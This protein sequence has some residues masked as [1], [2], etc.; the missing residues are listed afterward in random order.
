MF[1][2]INIIDIIKCHISTLKDYR[3]KKYSKCDLFLF[4]IFPLIVAGFIILFCGVI[5]SNAVTLLTTSLSIFA[6]LLFNLLLLVYNAIQKVNVTNNVEVK[7]EFLKQIFQNISFAIL[8]SVFA[9]ILLIIYSLTGN[10]CILLY[11]LTFLIFYMVTLFILTLM[12]I[13]KRTHILFSEE[14]KPL[15]K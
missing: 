10:N 14:I 8:V 11:I 15:F 5:S 9:I 13:L 4:F 1:D 3:T 7:K 6:A 2:K 12:M